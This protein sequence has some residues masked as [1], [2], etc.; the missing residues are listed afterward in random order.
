MNETPMTSEGL[1]T[2]NTV[3][4]AISDT[5]ETKGLPGIIILCTSEHFIKKNPT[6]CNT[7]SEILLF[8]FI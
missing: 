1:R 2:V 3:K 6:R 7:V 8:Q 4:V 5:S